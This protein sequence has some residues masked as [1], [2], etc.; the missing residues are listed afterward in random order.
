MGRGVTLSLATIEAALYAALEPL[1]TNVTTGTTEARPFA[2]LGRFA[3]EFDPKEIREV[4]SQYPALLL[5]F[6]G[7]Q[8]VRTVRTLA[9]DA[10]DRG[11]S[12]WTVYVCVEDPAAIDDATVGTTARPGGL[13][14]VDAVEGVLNG[15]LIPGTW[16]NQRLRSAGTREMLIRRGVVYIWAV[17][18]DV[19]RALPQV[20]PADTSVDLDEIAG[21]VN[22]EDT[23]NDDNPDN[24][25]VQFVADTTEA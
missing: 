4:C 7:E 9:G 20:T 24:P 15:L 19:M 18:F 22:L 2:M 11:T 1:V 23:L 21:D 17:A 3:G 14:L 12:T 10:E 5:A 8:S 25:R 16:M 6:A 13:R